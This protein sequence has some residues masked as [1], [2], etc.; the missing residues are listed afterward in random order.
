VLPP[1]SF[2]RL[3]D[4]ELFTGYFLC[5]RRADLGPTEILDEES[6]THFAEG[7]YF[8]FTE[9]APTNGTMLLHFVQ[10]S[11]VDNFR[12]A[13]RTTVASGDN[14]NRRI[15]VPRS[16]NSVTADIDSEY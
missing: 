8:P 11:C 4:V 7:E 6:M 5:A 15:P 12:L 9:W 14:E 2:A 3:G 10:Y 1:P 13:R 16:P